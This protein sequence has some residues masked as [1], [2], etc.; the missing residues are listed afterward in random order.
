MTSIGVGYVWDT[1]GIRERE[2]DK[3]S[4]SL[5]DQ[6]THVQTQS[7]KID[8][9]ARPLGET[10]GHDHYRHWNK[11]EKECTLEGKSR[12]QSIKCLKYIEQC[13]VLCSQVLE[14]CQGFGRQQRLK[15]KLISTADALPRLDDISAEA[16]GILGVLGI[17]RS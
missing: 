13:S 8:D 15:H 16:R 17:S 2:R 12:A 10:T 6:H 4:N 14:Q 9:W 5:D 11:R 7:D 1:C 3:E